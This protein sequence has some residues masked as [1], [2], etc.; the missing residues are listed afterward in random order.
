MLSTTC[1]DTKA[2]QGHGAGKTFLIKFPSYSVKLMQVKHTKNPV[3]LFAPMSVPWGTKV[4]SLDWLFPL[5]EWRRRPP[6]FT[7]QVPD[8][9]SQPLCAQQ[10]L[11]SLRAAAKSC[12][13]PPF[14]FEPSC[15]WEPSVHKVGG[16]QGPHVTTHRPHTH[17][18]RKTLQ[19]LE[20]SSIPSSLYE[21]RPS[22]RV[23]L[24]YHMLEPTRL[25]RQNRFSSE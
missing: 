23:G 15:S 20:K 5:T 24:T 12:S 25:E 1:I 13:S 16:G 6:P 19:K 2:W 4:I 3:R 9:A 18:R 14:G 8:K 10:A 7:T 21:S 22:L 17:R 11:E